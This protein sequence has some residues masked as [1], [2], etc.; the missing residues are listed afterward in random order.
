MQSLTMRAMRIRPSL[1]IPL[2]PSSRALVGP[3]VSIIRRLD[4]LLRSSLSHP[5]T[6]RLATLSNLHLPSSSP[7]GTSPAPSTAMSSPGGAG[8]V[9]RAAAR[10]TSLQRSARPKTACN[11]PGRQ[12][13][14]REAAQRAIL[15]PLAGRQDGR[16]TRLSLSQKAPLEAS[17]T[18]RSHRALLPSLPDP[19]DSILPLWLIVKPDLEPAFAFLGPMASIIWAAASSSTGGVPPMSLAG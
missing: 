2:S 10:T 12:Y 11:Y 8:H 3:L 1:Q 6:R 4:E 16:A 13:L 5:G 18:P 14:H 9:R 7:P 15:P 19:S 17:V